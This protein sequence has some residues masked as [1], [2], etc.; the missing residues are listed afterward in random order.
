MHWQ[1]R[2]ERILESR[3]GRIWRKADFQVFGQHGNQVVMEG[4]IRIDHVS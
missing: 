2:G 3:V 1:Q 4:V